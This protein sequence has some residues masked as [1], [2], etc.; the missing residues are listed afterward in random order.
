LIAVKPIDRFLLLPLAN[1][2]EPHCFP[3][4]ALGVT[5]AGTSVTGFHLFIA[6]G[7][8]VL[9][10]GQSTLKAHELSFF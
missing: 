6:P 9:F 1:R 7:D 4:E 8:I 10:V 5:Q 3:T 2:I